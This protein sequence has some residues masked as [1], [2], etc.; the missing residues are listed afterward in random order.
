MDVMIK[1]GTAAYVLMGLDVHVPPDASGNGNKWKNFG[2]NSQILAS[3]WVTFNIA[4][5]KKN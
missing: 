4:V 1:L 2:I 5:E 3:Q